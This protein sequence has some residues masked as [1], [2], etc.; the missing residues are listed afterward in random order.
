ME[1]RSSLFELYGPVAGSETAADIVRGFN[2]DA[3]G[4]QES[5]I[6]PVLYLRA[7]NAAI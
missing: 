3:G 2:V 7:E 6:M 4:G 1:H 5:S